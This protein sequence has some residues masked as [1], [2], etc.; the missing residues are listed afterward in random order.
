MAAGIFVLSFFIAGV[1][2]GFIFI[3]KRLDFRPNSAGNNYYGA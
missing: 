2:E 1:A 3:E